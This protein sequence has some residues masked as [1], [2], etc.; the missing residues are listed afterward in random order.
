MEVVDKGKDGAFA[1]GRDDSIYNNVI[2]NH[3]NI[4]QTF[5]ATQQLKTMLGDV[6]TGLEGDR[7]ERDEQRR[8]RL[9][10]VPCTYAEG[11]D[12][13]DCTCVDTSRGFSPA[14]CGVISCQNEN[15]LCDGTYN[16]PLIS[17]LITGKYYLFLMF[18]FVYII[19][20]HAK[21]LSCP[22]CLSCF[23]A[24][25]DDLDSDGDKEVDVCEDRF[26]PNILIR[27]A[28]LFRCDD[29]DTSKLCYTDKWFK[30]EKQ[31]LNFLEY[32][33][34][35]ADDCAPST[36]LSVELDKDTTADSTCE[37]TKYTITPF[38][39]YPECNNRTDVGP[40][41]L[42]FTNPL[43]GA[44][45]EVTVQLDEVAPV[46]ECGFLVHNANSSANMVDGQ[47]LYH[48]MLKT[49]GGGRRLNDARLK[50]AGFF[51]NVTV[52]SYDCVFDLAY[53]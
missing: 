52:S 27:D 36:K 38:Q 43:P 41:D 15:K 33:F 26:P 11:L 46:V 20:T 5:Y 12:L 53:Y 39:D 37:N 30:N 23:P 49:E 25:C 19:C 4:I 3:G 45:R 31:V 24:G 2:T 48:Y 10:S 50:D 35:A 42:T 9:Q 13:T 14:P 18:L 6:Q 28:K 29:D 1:G 40:F 34:A 51:Y 44:S 47:T 17:E 8:R 7:E 32:E 16:Y 21:Q 22:P